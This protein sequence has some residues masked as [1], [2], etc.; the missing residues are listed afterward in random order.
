MANLIR[1]FVRDC[2]ICTTS[3]SP[4]AKNLPSESQLSKVRTQRSLSSTLSLTESVHPSTSLLRASA[5][6]TT[7]L[8]WIKLRRGSRWWSIRLMVQS[9][10]KLRSSTSRRP[11]SWAASWRSG[12]QWSKSLTV[13]QL[14]SSSTYCTFIS[15]IWATMQPLM[16]STWRREK[17]PSHIKNSK[18][19][20]LATRFATESSWGI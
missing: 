1:W 8:R 13:T 14:Q 16:S 7:T 20:Q 12:L 3:W 11:W 6:W 18:L 5:W 19:M 17:L 4:R 10:S 9:S 2:S 15:T